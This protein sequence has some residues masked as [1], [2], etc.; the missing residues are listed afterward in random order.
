MK[1]RTYDIH[2]RVTEQEKKRMEAK[3]RKAKISLSAYLRRVGAEEDVEQTPPEML[4]AHM[5]EGVSNGHPK[6]MGS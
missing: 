3:A 2:I 1:Q 6:N 4:F 5:E